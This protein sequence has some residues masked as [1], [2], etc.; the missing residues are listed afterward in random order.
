MVRPYRIAVKD[1]ERFAPTSGVC[2]IVDQHPL[3]ATLG[4]LPFWFFRKEE[5]RRVYSRVLVL[6][7]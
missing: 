6:R 5:E 2:L 3:P 4:G 7:T 1:P